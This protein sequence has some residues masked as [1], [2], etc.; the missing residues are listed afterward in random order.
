MPSNLT[1]LKRDNSRIKGVSCGAQEFSS[2]GL[3]PRSKG[4]TMRRLGINALALAFTALTAGC[5]PSGNDIVSCD[6]QGCIS[7][8]KFLQ[9]ISSALK[10]KVVGYTTV[11]GG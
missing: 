2:S 8:A 11:V 3:W 4:E 7:Q 9:N 6:L 10:G 5:G 1:L